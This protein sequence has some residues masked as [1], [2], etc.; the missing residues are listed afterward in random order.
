MRSKSAGV[1]NRGAAL[2]L[3]GLV[4]CGAGCA[5]AGDGG[6]AEQSGDTPVLPPG[7]SIQPAGGGASGA[8]SG[9]TGIVTGGGP[10]QPGDVGAGAAGSVGSTGGTLP[11]DVDSVVKSRCQTCHGATPIGGAPMPL[12]TLADFGK[13]YTV[14]STPQ[15]LGQTMKVHEIVRIRVNKEQ[16][17]LPMPQGMPLSP[18]DLGL[19]DTWLAGG[20]QAGTACAGGTGAGGTGAGGTGAAGSGGTNLMQGANNQCDI[21][22][23]YEPLTA[24]DGETC[25]EFLT[26]DLSSPTDTT[27]FQ[28]PTGESYNQ[29]Y[30]AVPWPA[31]TVATRFGANFDNLPV[32]HHWL[33]FKSASGNP[34]GTVAKDVTGTTLGEAAELV[35]GWAVGGCNTEF[36]PDVGLKLPDSGAIMIQWHHFNNTG[37][38]ALDGSIVQWCTLPEGMRANIGGLTFLGTENFNGPIG[39]PPG[40]NQ[41]AGACVNDSG[42]DI[43][44][45]GFE[46]HMHLIG[47]RMT[48]VIHRAAGGTE[49]VFD[50]AFQFDQQYNYLMNPPIVLKA[51]DVIE[52]TCTFNNTNP[53]NVAFGQSTQQEMCYQFALAYPYDALNNGVL[54]LIGATNTCW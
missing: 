43:S 18:A 26:H 53:A 52:S 21:A 20:A 24:R 39:M 29:L 13:D 2:V 50:Q 40:M 38:T 48:S 35:G 51:G 44:I 17:T 15:L 34:A 32:L 8:G 16:G 28:V 49:T 3:L 19:L 7:A 47:V 1:G 14:K 42:G 30:Y 5:G 31:G 23:N 12:V 45:F 25:Y 46:P 37:G 4:L 27:K 33:G 41:F 22:T 11:C 9:A 10:S 54:S 36:P 6:A